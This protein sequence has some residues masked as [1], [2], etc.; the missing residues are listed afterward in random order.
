MQGRLAVGALETLAARWLPP[1]LGEFQEQHP[2]L[3]PDLR[4]AGTAEL[5]NAVKESALDVCF[6]FTPPPPGLGL[7]SECVG[8][9]ELV[10]LLPAR[11]PLA[12]EASVGPRQ[13]SGQRFLVT[14]PGCAYRSM[15][16]SA[17]S[18]GPGGPPPIAGEYG[19]LRAIA[20]LVQAGLG[21]ALM[22]RLALDGAD[23]TLVAVPWDGANSRVAIH[24]IWR[25]RQLPAALRRF[26][27]LIRL[28]AAC[29]H[30]PVSAVDLQHA[31]G[32]EAVSHEEANRI[33]NVVDVA[34]AA[35]R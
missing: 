11:H 28:H 9:D 7:H 27:D 16:D 10:L 12:A 34:D 14:A 31:A 32:G 25:P 23:G 17:F 13:A 19:S 1:H 18:S 6:A 26:Q 15:F 22:P 20:A 24:M 4:I 5:H 8:A 33:G 21:C 2:A 3:Q 29:L 35:D 30:Q